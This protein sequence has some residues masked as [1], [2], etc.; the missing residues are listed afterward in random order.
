MCL[1]RLVC[2]SSRSSN[3]QGALVSPAPHGEAGG[4]AS[5]QRVL[6]DLSN[7]SKRSDVGVQSRQ[8][9]Q[10]THP[11]SA[12]ASPAALPGSACSVCSEEQRLP[13]VAVCAQAEVGARIHQEQGREAE[14]THGMRVTAVRDWE[15]GVPATVKDRT[16]YLKMDKLTEPAASSPRVV[17]ECGIHVPRP[18]E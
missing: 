15:G 4:A 16:G 18:H 9:I 2:S 17:A 12:E 6:A 13:R 5:C 1:L 10:C 3:P 7:N 8:C 14:A 11:E